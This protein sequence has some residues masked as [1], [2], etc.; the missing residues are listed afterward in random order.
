MTCADCMVSGCECGKD[1]GP[2][3]CVRCQEEFYRESDAQPSMPLVT[4]D[5]STLE[6]RSLLLHFFD[7]HQYPGKL[8]VVAF[9][10][11]H[12]DIRQV[13]ID[14]YVRPWLTSTG[15]YGGKCQPITTPICP[16]CEEEKVHKNGA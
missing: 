6:S 12:P 7:Q 15:V 3:E 4:C 10:G 5:F 9:L 1:G 16:E 8:S 11:K 14:R 13:F 2:C